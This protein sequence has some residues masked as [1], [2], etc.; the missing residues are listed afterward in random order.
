LALALA[1]L[2]C[3]QDARSDDGKPPARAAASGREAAASRFDTTAK[4]AAEA[5][6]A[7][8][9]EEAAAHYRKALELKPDWTDGRWALATLLYDLDRHAE[10]RDEFRRIVAA[11]PADGVALAL[12]ALCGLRLRDY[13]AALAGLQQAH[14]LGI[15][16]PEVRSVATLQLALLL[17]RVGRHEAAFELLRPFAG[18]GS[19]DPS[20]LAAFGL[21]M[22]RM[23]NMPDQVPKERR[24]M[25]LLAGRG[26]YHMARG[27]R[28]AVGRL[29]LEELVS[30]YPGE[31]NVHYAF[32]AY[33]APEEPDAAIEAFRREL[34]AT[35]DHHP[36]LL[37]IA[38]I[39]TRRGNAAE[40]VP[41]AERA[42]RLAPEEPAPHLVLGRALLE[43]GDT[44]RAVAELEASARLAPESREVQF[45]LARAYQRAGRSEDAERARREFL[46]LERAAGESPA[47]EPQPSPP[48]AP[49]GA[50]PESGGPK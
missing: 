26:G 50:S 38:S 42:A 15:P 33:V 5:R 39:E 27:R 18:Q 10:A 29:A 49:G 48:E 2:L 34:R 30:R 13:D 17:N 7:G 6:E 24:E 25:V 43:L 36:S 45:A 44:A 41:L 46:R 35:P 21:S 9:L 31:P 47:P 14:A 22:L 1:W 37:Q 3:A 12:M 40:A 11:R 8:R 28:T 19:D 32:G 20:V 16:S 4:K 23:K